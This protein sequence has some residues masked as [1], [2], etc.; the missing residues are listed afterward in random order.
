MDLDYIIV[1]SGM[2]GLHTAY[3][4]GQQGKK[5][6]VLEKESYP[7]GRMSSHEINGSFVDFG[8]K[9][10]SNIYRHML[11]LAKELGVEPVPINLTNIG[12]M[13]EGKLYAF[14]GSK[15]FSAALS[16]KGISLKAKLRLG[17]AVAYALVK[18][19]DLDLYDPEKELFLD[20]KSI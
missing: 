10:I 8:A 18:Y 15:R 19:R 12:I 2:A 1:G 17:L 6:L 16:Y 5:V 9:F 3:R 20:D 7:G 14:D 13:K 11:P 4:L